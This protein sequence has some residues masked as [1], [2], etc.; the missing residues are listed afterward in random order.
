MPHIGSERRAGYWWECTSDP[1]HTE[2]NFEKVATVPLVRFLVDLAKS[3]WDQQRLSVPCTKCGAGRMRIT[4]DFPRSVE[5]VRLSVVHV[6]GLTGNLPEYLPML[7]QADPH[8]EDEPWIDFKYVSWSKDRGYQSYGLARPA[9]FSRS[10]LRTLFE[11]YKNV[12]GC[13]VLG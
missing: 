9:V 13:E 8:D 2:S 10:G 5:P 11:T 3:G 6:V 7:W 4:Y 1:S 12:V